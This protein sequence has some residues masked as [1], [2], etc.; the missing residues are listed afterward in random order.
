VT[1]LQLARESQVVPP[2]EETVGDVVAA[3]QDEGSMGYAYWQSVE[4]RRRTARACDP[5]LPR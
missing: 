3:M 2:R 5:L 1:L 4:R